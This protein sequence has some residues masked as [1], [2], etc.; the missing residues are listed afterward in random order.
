MEK[1]FKICGNFVGGY[2]TFLDVKIVEKLWGGVVDK[3]QKGLLNAIPSSS[4]L[5]TYTQ[6]FTFLITYTLSHLPI[7]FNTLNICTVEAEYGAGW[8]GAVPAEVPEDLSASTA[9][10]DASPAARVRE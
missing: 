10:G 6:S 5:I 9:G 8:G 2:H 4:Y 7:P 1:L 3:R